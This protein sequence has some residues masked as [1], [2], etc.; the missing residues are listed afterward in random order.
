M[1]GWEYNLDVEKQKKCLLNFCG[2]G[3]ALESSHMEGQ[4]GDRR[5]EQ[6]G[7]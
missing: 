2:E 4:G 6:Y 3:N 7:S 5:I 1:I